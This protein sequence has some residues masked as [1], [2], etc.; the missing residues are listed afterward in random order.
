MEE[1]L[2]PGVMAV[3]ALKDP[4]NPSSMAMVRDFLQAH[5]D[6][7]KA[8]IAAYN[9]AR[10]LVIAGDAQEISRI[11]R[12]LRGGLVSCVKTLPGVQ[13]AFHSPL[14]REATRQFTL[15]ASPL[16]DEIGEHPPEDPH[17]IV[18]SVTGTLVTC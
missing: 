14:M 18:S 11:G 8:S 16:L 4:G 7:E 10:Q 5:L 17:K 13:C 6:P 15:Q 12:V 1:T 9:S 3:V 2:S